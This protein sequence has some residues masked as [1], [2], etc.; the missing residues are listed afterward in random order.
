MNGSVS[1]IGISV[2][3]G[4]EMVLC[5]HIVIREWNQGKRLVEAL[6]LEISF[7]PMSKSINWMDKLSQRMQH[8]GGEVTFFFV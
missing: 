8:Q 6:I 3:E 5:F 4:L 1:K 7:L 2:V